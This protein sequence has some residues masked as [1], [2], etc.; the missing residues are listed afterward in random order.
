MSLWWLGALSRSK[1]LEFRCWMWTAKWGCSFLPNFQFCGLPL[2]ILLVL[3]MQDWEVFCLFLCRWLHWNAL[4]T[5][6]LHSK[7]WN[8]LA[9]GLVYRRFVSLLLLVAFYACGPNITWTE[10]VH[11]VKD[12]RRCWTEVW[13]QNLNVVSAY[14]SLLISQIA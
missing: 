13:D 4:A 8:L 9:R 3:D 10:S 14:C 2:R 7:C 12:W 11:T 6:L 1:S 5:R